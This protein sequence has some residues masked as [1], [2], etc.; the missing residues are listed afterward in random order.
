[1]PWDP[2][3]CT[4]AEVNLAHGHG[5][6][7]HAADAGPVLDSEHLDAV[8]ND[9]DDATAEVVSDD[10]IRVELVVLVDERL[11]HLTLVLEHTDVRLSLLFESLVQIVG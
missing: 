8:E 5:V 2:G 11:D 1:L 7:L 10:E 6:S 9:F 3:A 4:S